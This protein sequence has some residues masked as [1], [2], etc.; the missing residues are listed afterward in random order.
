MWGFSLT[1]KASHPELAEV[2]P[3]T[4]ATIFVGTRKKGVKNWGGKTRLSPHSGLEILRFEL[5]L[6][7]TVSEKYGEIQHPPQLAQVITGVDSVDDESVPDQLCARRFLDTIGEGSGWSEL[8]TIVVNPCDPTIPIVDKVLFSENK[9]GD[10]YGSTCFYTRLMMF[11]PLKEEFFRRDGLQPKVHSSTQKQIHCLLM[12]MSCGRSCG[13]W[14]GDTQSSA[15]EQRPQTLWISSGLG[16]WIFSFLMIGMIGK[17]ATKNSFPLISWHETPVLLATS[18]TKLFVVRWESTLFVLFLLHVCQYMQAQL[19][20]GF[21]EVWVFL[22][23]WAS[24]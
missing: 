8:H 1:T 17:D 5:K 3:A 7:P 11:F 21:I 2:L 23:I 6:V 4:W 12:V 16:Q 18:L 14:A 24:E 20:V 15:R 9:N 22:L 19:G 10:D 13:L